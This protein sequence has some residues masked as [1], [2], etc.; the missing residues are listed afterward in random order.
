MKMYL[1]LPDAKSGG[2]LRTWVEPESLSTRLASPSLSTIERIR[3]LS[4]A[5]AGLVHADMDHDTL[6]EYVHR[7]RI[8]VGNLQPALENQLV[9]LLLPANASDIAF[10]TQCSELYGN[11]AAI[12]KRIIL[13]APQDFRHSVEDLARISQACYWGILFLG[14]RLRYAYCSYTQPPPGL[15]LEI[16]QIYEFSRS[17]KI[18]KHLLEGED[19]KLRNISHAYKRVLLFGIC[20]PY[21]FTFRGVHS[22]YRMLDNYAKLASLRSGRPSKDTCLFLINPEAD[23]PATPMLPKLSMG[24]DTLYLDTSALVSVLNWD[25]DT[26]HSESTLK[27]KP[28]EQV[29]KAL[30]TKELLRSLM[31][32][33]GIYASRRTKRKYKKSSCDFVYGLSSTATLLGLKDKK[34]D[35]KGSYVKTDFELVDESVSG[36]RLLLKEEDRVHVRVGEIVALKRKRGGHWSVGMIRWAQTDG[37]HEF[38]IGIY[39]FIDNAIPV[40]IS[41]LEDETPARQGVGIWATKHKANQQLPTLIVDPKF[42]ALGKTIRVERGDV[43]LYFEMGRALFS[44]RYFI[45]F[46]ANLLNSTPER[47]AELVTPLFELKN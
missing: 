19:T 1:T 33:W 5:T 27:E 20:D 12:C 37:E 22:V 18:A 39:K 36:A 44:T 8:A 45:W 14:E 31:L 47:S 28:R 30:E 16:H 7:Y 46:E 42:Y 23:R 43:Q 32:N 41:S 40:S 3:I 26:T 21:Q 13:N 10:C 4:D 25:L 11:L 34:I 35:A 29:C 24:V 17:R 2:P 9:G 6:I 38:Y 15:W